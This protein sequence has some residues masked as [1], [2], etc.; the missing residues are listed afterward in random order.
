VKSLFTKDSI[1]TP[2]KIWLFLLCTQLNTGRV[3]ESFIIAS[4]VFLCRYCESA[5]LA[6]IESV[7]VKLIASEGIK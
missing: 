5:C 4:W 2:L 7:Y 6:Y 3:L 1:Y